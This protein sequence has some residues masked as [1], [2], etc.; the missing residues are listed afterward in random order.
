ML[1][2]H[3]LDEYAHYLRALIYIEQMD[4]DNALSSLRQAVYC[5]SNFILAHYVLGDVYSRLGN[6][7]QAQKEWQIAYRLVSQLG[8]ESL[9]PHSTDL[10]AEMLEGLL[11]MQL[12]HGGT[13]SQ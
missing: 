1:E 4:F 10:S 11:K 5:N 6:L 13:I 3:P 12:E 2:S 7:K 8:S 9:I